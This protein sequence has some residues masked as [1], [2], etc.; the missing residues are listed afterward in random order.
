MSKNTP[1]NFPRLA[2]DSARHIADTRRRIASGQ[3]GIE[4]LDPYGRRAMRFKA[5]IGYVM[6]GP[7]LDLDVEMID[8]EDGERWDGLG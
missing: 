1:H 7:A 3:I 2:Q 4:E 5:A 8:N 6:P